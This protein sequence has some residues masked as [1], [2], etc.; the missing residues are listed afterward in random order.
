MNEEREA[1]VKAKVETVCRAEIPGSDGEEVRVALDV[2][3]CIERIDG[4]GKKFPRMVIVRFTSRSA[5]FSKGAK[6]NEFLKSSN[7]QV[8]EDLTAGRAT[9][10]HLWLFVEQARKSIC[11]RK[12][13]QKM[14][15]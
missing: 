9:H 8:K 2:A 14:N 5:T 10:A 4:E 6:N 12:R 7:L 11:E 15:I 13:N 3:H 1:N